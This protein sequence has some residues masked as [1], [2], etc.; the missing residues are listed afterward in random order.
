MVVFVAL[1][2]LVFLLGIRTR[3]S[4]D[5]ILDHRDT[6]I[7]NGIFVLFIFLSHCTQ[8]WLYKTSC[9]WTSF[10][11]TYKTSIISGSSQPF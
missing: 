11:S 7:I 2:V 10:T 1:I 9:Y 8:Y 4:D 5:T 6:S 3:K